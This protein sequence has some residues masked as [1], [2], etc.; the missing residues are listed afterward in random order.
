MFF[1]VCCGAFPFTVT[2]YTRKWKW[3]IS[4]NIFPL[5][6]IHF[7]SIQF[8]NL[9]NFCPIT[10]CVLFLC[11]GWHF[12]NM[13][14]S[15]DEFNHECCYTTAVRYQWELHTKPEK[16][17]KKKKYGKNCIEQNEWKWENRKY[18]FVIAKI[19]YKSIFPFQ[20][21]FNS[22]NYIHVI[23]WNPFPKLIK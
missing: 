22:G 15:S 4:K 8:R 12:V 11:A 10:K 19:K 18:D 1:I 20:I 21:N 3:L 16:K 17:W 23:T 2:K 5:N 6:S 14:F 7:N 9:I 13:V